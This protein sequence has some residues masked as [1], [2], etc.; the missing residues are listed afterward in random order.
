MNVQVFHFL[1]E[2]L[3]FVW[4]LIGAGFLIFV[5]VPRQ[6]SFAQLVEGNDD[7]S[8]EDVDKKE[9]EDNEVDDIENGHFYPEHWD[10]AFIFI[11]R[12][13]GVLEDIHP[14]FGGLYSK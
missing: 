14:A 2:S 8:D 6:F 1:L 12:G 5:N 3:V 4:C 9:W 13:H 11:G 7:Q 10:R